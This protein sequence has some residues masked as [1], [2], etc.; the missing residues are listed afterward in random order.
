MNDAA[1]GESRYYYVC[2][3]YWYPV[4]ANDVDTDEVTTCADAVYITLDESIEYMMENISNIVYS[5]RVDMPRL[6]EIITMY[7]DPVNNILKM[8][9]PLNNKYK[10]VIHRVEMF[11]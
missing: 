4:R 3:T 8:S 7:W 9:T 11:K 1:I 6:R 10:F 5:G 2:S